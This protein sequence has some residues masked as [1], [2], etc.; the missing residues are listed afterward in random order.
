MRQ[1]ILKDDENKLI[2]TDGDF[3]IGTSDQQHVG[4]IFLSHPGEFK[5]FPVV[6][7][8]A[9]KYLKTRI[10]EDEF[11]RDLKIQLQ[12]DGYQNAGIDTSNGIAKLKIEI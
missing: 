3:T 1:D 11:K 12:Y 5:E 7:F 10:T 4:D 2:F 9:V 6:G 8:G